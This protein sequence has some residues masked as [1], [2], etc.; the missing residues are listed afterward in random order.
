MSLVASVLVGVLFASGTYLILRKDVLRVVWGIALISQ[1]ANVTV[2]TVGGLD[3]ARAPIVGD[4]GGTLMDPLVQALI[5]TAVVIGLGAT[6]FTLL[7]VYRVYEENDSVNVDNISG[8]D[9]LYGITGGDGGS[10]E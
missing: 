2:L 4:G 1:A 6:A 3:A 9:D 5:L 8:R 10:K 7:L